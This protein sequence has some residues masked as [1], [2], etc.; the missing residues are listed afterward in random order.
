MQIKSLFYNK[1]NINGNIFNFLHFIYR[2]HVAIADT[3]GNFLELE[4]KKKTMD[5][6]SGFYE[7]D[8]EEGMAASVSSSASEADGEESS[9]ELG[10]DDTER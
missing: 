7:E 2:D 3:I 4:S 5:P 6:T 8:E 9:E 1:G 10:E